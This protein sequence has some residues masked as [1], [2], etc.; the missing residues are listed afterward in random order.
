MTRLEALEA[1]WAWVLASWHYD[2]W[3]S[4]LEGNELE[5]EALRLGLM[6]QVPYNPAVHGEIDAEPGDGI[7]VPVKAKEWGS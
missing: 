6:R 3:C 1:L 2:G 5:A 7:S 4:D